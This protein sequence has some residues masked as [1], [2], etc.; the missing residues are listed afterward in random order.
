VCFL[1]GTAVGDDAERAWQIHGQVVD[2]HGQPTDDFDAATFWWANGHQYDANGERIHK[3]GYEDLP[4]IASNEGDPDASPKAFAEHL[5]DGKFKL[6]EKWRPRIALFAF[7]KARKRGGLVVVEKT[8]AAEDVTITLGPLTRV[9]GKVVC[10]EQ[11]NRVPGV[12]D[13]N[14]RPV[15]D[16]ESFLSFSYCASVRGQFA[17]LVPPG[18][19]D[20]E[21]DSD[22]PTARMPKPGERKLKNAPDDM[23]AYLSGI[24]IDVPEQPEFD[25]GTLNVELP[26]DKNG[27]AHDITQFY[28]KEPP[29]LTITDARG[30][31]KTVKLSDYRGKW[32]ILD[33]W[34]LWCHPCV[35]SS[36]P[37]LSKFYE[38]HAAERDRFEI[39]AICNTSEE[40]VLTVADF[41]VKELPVRKEIWKDKD[42]PF[43]VLIDG[44]AATAAEYGIQSWPTTFLIDPEG[45][46]VKHG[47]LEMLAK[48]LESK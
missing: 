33:F 37:D 19:Y 25:L 34:A 2:E 20:L 24:R 28:G 35:Y 46:L 5:P 11:N 15:G 45:H 17:F 10:A 23:P 40:K 29:L 44:E 32:V 26:K 9:H 39:L 21:V 43:P 42:L 31:P 14:I 8:A 18:K 27:K 30:V 13:A 12:V 6:T 16:R 48:K 3:G 1:A 47:S 22:E 7:D 36:L 38:E 41:E 4:N